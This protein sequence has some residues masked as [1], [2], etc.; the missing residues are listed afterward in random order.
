MRVTE[1]PE[2]G[3]NRRKFPRQQASVSPNFL[4]R[5]HHPE[6]T[7]LAQNIESSRRMKCRL[8]TV[9]MRQSPRLVIRYSHPSPSGIQT[10]KETFQSFQ[11]SRARRESWWS[12]RTR[13]IF[14]SVF[15]PGSCHSTTMFYIL[16]LRLRSTSKFVS[17]LAPKS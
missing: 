8:A 1:V 14:Q 15:T 13:I 6:I 4:K 11:V 7:H 17:S 10:Y 3:Q 5:Q 12:K 16:T 2:S 9:L